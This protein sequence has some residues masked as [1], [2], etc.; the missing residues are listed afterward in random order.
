M[1]FNHAVTHDLGR[2]CPEQRIIPILL[3]HRIEGVRILL[4]K[5]GTDRQ[6]RVVANLQV[7]FTPDLVIQLQFRRATAGVLDAGN[8]VAMGFRN[9][10]TNRVQAVLAGHFGQHCSHISLSRFLQDARRLTGLGIL[11]NDPAF[12]I[13]SISGNTRKL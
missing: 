9:G 6:A 7:A 2:T 12:R 8:P 10:V 4:L 11:V 5:A 3:P 1:G 13:G